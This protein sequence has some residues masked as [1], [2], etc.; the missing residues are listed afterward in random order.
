MVALNPESITLPGQPNVLACHICAAEHPGTAP[1]P[2]SFTW[3]PFSSNPRGSIRP[4]GSRPAQA[5]TPTLVVCSACAQ[6]IANGLGIEFSWR[7]ARYCLAQIAGESGDRLFKIPYYVIP[8]A[9]YRWVL[10]VSGK[11]ANID[12]VGFR[13]SFRTWIDSTTAL[14]LMWAAAFLTALVILINFTR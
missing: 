9:G 13:S 2:A 5:K 1:L 3:Q 4:L 14:R 10:S 11:V 6:N 12:R 8:G 7:R